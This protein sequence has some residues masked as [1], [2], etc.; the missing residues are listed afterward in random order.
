MNLPPPLKGVSD[1]LARSEQAP[2]TSRDMLNMRPKDCT[3]DRV[4]LSQR[5][6]QALYM[7]DTLAANVAVTPH[8]QVV[9]PVK[10]LECVTFQQ[11]TVDYAEKVGAHLGTSNVADELTVSDSRWSTATPSALPVPAIK[12]DRQGNVYAIDGL[13]GIVKFNSRGEQQW[14][15]ALPAADADATVRAL[16]VAA[17][18]F[19]D[20]VGDAIYAGVSA[21]GAQSRAAMW[22]YKQVNTTTAS[23]S[24]EVKTERVWE[25][26]P[27]AF[28]EMMEVRDGE[29]FTAQNEPDKGQAWV[30]VYFNINAAAPTLAREWEVP[31]PV[32]SLDVK[33]SDGSVLT[34]HEPN[35]QRGL[36][37]RNPQFSPRDLAKEWT[38][39]NLTALDK[40]LWCDFNA[41]TI[42]TALDLSDGDPITLWPDD[43]PG[44][45]SLFQT[46]AVA[47]QP[48][49][50]ENGIGGRPAIR[51][52]GV[53]ATPNLVSQ[54][55]P[56]IAA[57]YD[58]Q[59]K[60]LLP[61]FNGARWAAFI[62]FR[63]AEEATIRPL[64]NQ[65]DSANAG[66]AGANTLCVNKDSTTA[67]VTT[68]TARGKLTYVTECSA[69]GIGA[70]VGAGAANSI[71]TGAEYIYSGSNGA[72]ILTIVYDGGTE[73]TNDEA[74]HSMLRVN[75]RPVD[76]WVS[77]E[78]TGLGATTVGGFGSSAL[79][80]YLQGD[81]AR[82][83]VLR[84]YP[85]GGLQGNPVTGAYSTGGSAGD[86]HYPRAVGAGI[87]AAVNYEV[88]AGNRYNDNEIERIEGWL[89]GEYGMS[90]ILP[91]GT[92][93]NLVFTA[94]AT[95]GA[96]T[97]TIDGI[98]Y[99][100]VAVPAAPY[101][102]GVGANAC[103]TASN[104]VH[105]INGTSVPGATTYFAGTKPHPTC[106]ASQ[107]NV[108]GGGA[109]ATVKIETKYLT[110]VAVSENNANMSWT[111][112]TTAAQATV[113]T[114]STVYMPGHYPHPFNI[115]Y[116]F[117]R[118]DVGASIGV[119]LESK[120]K[121]L[122]SK[123]GILAR[124]TSTGQI[125]WVHTSRRAVTTPGSIVLPAADVFHGGIGY[126]CAFGTGNGVYSYGPWATSII[127]GGSTPTGVV[128]L[129]AGFYVIGVTS[130]AVLLL[131]FLNGGGTFRAILLSGNPVAGETL[132]N[133]N[134]AGAEEL[135]G[136]T[137][138]DWTTGG[139][140]S[141][142]L[143][144]R[145][146]DLAESVTVP[147]SATGA[148]YAVA[149]D[150]TSSGDT[151][152]LSQSYKYPRIAVD[153]FDNV[154]LPY[155]CT[156]E[157][158]GAGATEAK[159]TY[160]CVG[161]LDSLAGFE[162]RYGYL[163]GTG[164]TALGGLCCAVDPKLPDYQGDP[165]EI[166]FACYVGTR[167]GWTV[168]TAGALTLSKV[169]AVTATINGDP[170]RAT[171]Y[172][173]V[174]NGYVRTFTT[175]GPQE[176]GGSGSLSQPVLIA[177]SRFV[178]TA[179]L[180]GEVFI[181]DGRT[182][183]VYKARAD[184]T[185]TWV[186]KTAGE[187]KPRARLLCAWRGRMV[188]ARFAD[189]AHDW[190]MSAM[191]NPYDFD[192]A[193]PVPTATQSVLG[194]QATG[195][196]K[197]PD[198]INALIPYSDDLLIFLCQSSIYRMD[199]DPAENGRFSLISDSTGGSF[200]NSWCK[201]ENG[202]VYFHGSRGGVY[203][204]VPGSLPEDISSQSI[205][206]RLRTIDLETY[207]VE[208][209]WNDIDDGF[210]L[211]KIPYDEDDAA[212]TAEHYFWSRQMQGW[213][214]DKIGSAAKQPMSS[215][216]I[217]GDALTNRRMILGGVDGQIRVWTPDANDDQGTAINSK[218]LIGPLRPK[219]DEFETRFTRL[220]VV[221][222]L[223]GSG[224]SYR[225]FATD[226]PDDLGDAVYLG[227]LRAGRNHNEPVRA[228]GSYVAVELAN[229][230]PDERF[231]IENIEVDAVAAG[232][233]RVRT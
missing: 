151:D 12:V 171:K 221:L 210:H 169:E 68:S 166:A 112:A 159:R 108:Q 51:F 157:N 225:F 206:N 224:A 94:N 25:F 190:H 202:V 177:G 211:F 231:A 146:I 85:D 102:V 160:V 20:G 134:T 140:P 69:A 86:F 66:V 216:T 185:E 84:D 99:S 198:I 144:L 152:N 186:S 114:N 155:W 208:M 21:G 17:V 64:F 127:E 162:I 136:I 233:K 192:I 104:L 76:R 220:Q 41:A 165:V 113:V 230:N 77:L 78:A 90:H 222:G 11:K 124:W 161:T 212:A 73:S 196:G 1:L 203:R 135:Q 172:V 184:K 111:N 188:R 178:S 105:A 62:V 79:T 204:L 153:T 115:N 163:A 48:T 223:P 65:D 123:E 30:R 97:V 52:G 2:L 209:R 107:S 6:G 199:G 14:K 72:V 13:A 193:P 217:D 150:L 173:G 9:E 200:G 170:P 147:S 214:P 42:G 43:G 183:V 15:V 174:S 44:F 18:G 49:Y 36:D 119:T 55:N 103:V 7:A 132:R 34:A 130:G 59:Q 24:T 187:M 142:A 81:I 158:Y 213:F 40:R 215:L 54:A 167:L 39:R 101:D 232:R 91:C 83:I 137:F 32:N 96:D 205:P 93:S 118:P 129:A 197:C 28:I 31:Y 126:A 80:T 164:T 70:A 61:A 33:V 4:R 26:T 226:T 110:A 75:G 92:A 95:A 180:F 194:T 38:I 88:V 58:D 195:I 168:D 207:R 23:G 106:I 35:P 154:Y 219:E 131:T 143:C 16:D 100:F 117:P 191:N 60:T 82:M 8:V 121:M 74:Q 67:A 125:K 53:T 122:T 57:Q 47:F 89:A 175:A 139:G 228:L 156:N 141:R 37:P 3:N 145:C 19:I 63:P 10:A 176:P 87:G 179:V 109:S 182:D 218:V 50:V 71:P 181:T 45:R 5:A 116:G 120:G 56:S 138:V 148:W 29:L 227:E 201:D 133:G 27:G 229:G 149:A 46:G 22:C 98:V 189:D 128:N